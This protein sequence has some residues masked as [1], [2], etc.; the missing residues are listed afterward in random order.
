MTT[1]IINPEYYLENETT[2]RAQHYIIFKGLLW[3]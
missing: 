3:N 2:E 1:C